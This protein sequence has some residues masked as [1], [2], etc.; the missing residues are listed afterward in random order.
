G[1]GTLKFFPA[2]PA[3]GPAMLNALA[4]PFSE[5]RFI[6]TGGVS[7]GNLGSYLSLSN[8]LAC[9]G[10][11]MVKRGWLASRDFDAIRT[12]ASDALRLANDAS[13]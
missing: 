12:A 11:W 2:E 8:V 10:S 3:G 1:I 6:P 9:G 5:A 13:A 7:R 4:G